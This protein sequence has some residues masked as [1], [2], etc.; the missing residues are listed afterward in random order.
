ASAY[1]RNKI[2]QILLDHGA[3]VNMQGGEYGNALGAAS[4]K[5]HDKIVQMLLDHGA[6]ASYQKAGGA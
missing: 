6:D 3:D 2:V 5:G 4:V 1:G